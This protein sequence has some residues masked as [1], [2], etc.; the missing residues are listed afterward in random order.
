MFRIAETPFVMQAKIPVTNLAKISKER[1]R[2][3]AGGMKDEKGRRKPW[4]A[5]K[6]G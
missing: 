5:D 1:R 6:K 3:T 4:K 2:H